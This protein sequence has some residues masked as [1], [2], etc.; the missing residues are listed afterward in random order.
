MEIERKFLIH[1]LP[2]DYKQYPFHKIE[3]GYLSIDPVIRARK[4]DDQYYLT[5]KSRG[6]LSREEVNLPLSEESYEHLKKKSDGFLI[7]K[8]R[9]LIPYLNHFT[10]ELD[11]FEGV[12]SGL[13]IAEVEFS[14]EEEAFAFQVPDWFK[15]DV[16]TDPQYQNCNL[17]VSPQTGDGY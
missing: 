6:L 12:N 9:Y 10:I 13:I 2:M 16:T 3:Q 4:E 11:I 17:S 1:S 8:T 5:Y 7:T 14:S 15:K